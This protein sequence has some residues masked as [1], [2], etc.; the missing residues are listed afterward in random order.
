MPESPSLVLDAVEIAA[1]AV[2]A[3]VPDRLEA[4]RS[5]ASAQCRCPRASP[6]HYARPAATQ[7]R[8]LLDDYADVDCHACHSEAS[9]LRRAS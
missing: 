7:M 5:Q 6:L 1:A 4:R 8:W 9:K 3:A 2:V